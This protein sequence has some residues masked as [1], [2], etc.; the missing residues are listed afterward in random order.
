[1]VWVPFCEVKFSEDCRELGKRIEEEALF[2]L[3]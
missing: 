1:M 3:L 2:L